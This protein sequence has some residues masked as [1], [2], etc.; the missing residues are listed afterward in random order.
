MTATAPTTRP[1]P[2]GSSSEVACTSSAMFEIVSMV[3]NTIATGI[4]I[5]K[6]PTV[7][8]VPKST[9]RERSGSSTG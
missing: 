3:P 1:R 9:W 6:S 5:R 4:A 8:V 2:R 7:G